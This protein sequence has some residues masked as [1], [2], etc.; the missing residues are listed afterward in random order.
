MG[1]RRLLRGFTL[2]EL[3]VVVAIIAILAAMLLPALSAAREKARRASC[4]TNMKQIGTALMAYSSDYNGYLPSWP[5]W[6][7]GETT[8]CL[9]GTYNCDSNNA[10]GTECHGYHGTRENIPFAQSAS[11]YTTQT[12]SMYQGKPG[13]SA[14]ATTADVRL[15]L[16]SIAAYGRGWANLWRTIGFGDKSLTS[17]NFS[18]GLLN[19]GPI[20]LGLLLVGGHLSDAKSFYC[21]SASGMTSENKSGGNFVGVYGLPHWQEAGGF[22][23]NALQYGDFSNRQ[24]ISAELPTLCSYDYRNVPLGVRYPWCKVVEIDANNANHYRTALTGTKNQIFGHIGGAYFRSLRELGGRCIVSDTFTKGGQYDALGVSSTGPSRLDDARGYI[25][26]ATDA[27]FAKSS[28]I[29]GYGFK[30]HRSVYNNLYGDGSVR[31]YGDPQERLIWH[32]Q[33]T[34]NIV[35]AH[36]DMRHILGSNYMG[37]TYNSPFWHALG[38]VEDSRFRRQGVAVWHYFDVQG[39]VDVDE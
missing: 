10:P 35:W 16:T 23:G 22:D 2:I 6:F 37:G 18:K 36:S 8:W 14:H 3:L 25:T 31:P 4:A 15:S 32:E 9:P 11:G 33:G 39:G 7:G 12:W 30:A 21:P 38:N 5:G 27:D 34:S 17:D 24:R 19:Q 13:I 28:M 26:S 1:F 29:V 20:G